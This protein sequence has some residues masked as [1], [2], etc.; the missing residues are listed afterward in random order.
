MSEHD[1]MDRLL[2]QALSTPVPALS[3]D[4][5]RR[6]LK[7]VRPRRLSR[8][9]IFTLAAYTMVALAISVSTMRHTEIGWPF[10]VVSVMVPILV[11]ALV[12]R[13]EFG[14]SALS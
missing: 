11:V 1:S 9:S 10:I 14:A 2:R 3:P 12:F 13:R 4:F 5:D 6:V 8:A 7:Q